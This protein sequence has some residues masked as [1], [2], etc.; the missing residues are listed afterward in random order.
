MTSVFLISFIVLTVNAYNYNTTEV[1]AVGGTHTE[2]VVGQPRFINPIYAN[3]DADRDLVQLTFSGLLKYDRD[4]NI[5]ED[6]AESFQIDSGGTTYT[7]HLKE[8]LKWS[9]GKPLTADDVIFTIQTIQDPNFKSPL[10]ASWVG[11]DIEKIDDLTV[12]F[13]LK[14]PYI[15][16]LENAT[17]PIL[18]KH[19]W[20]DTGAE[21]FAFASYNLNPVGSGMFKVKS[22]KERINSI[23]R[24]VLEQNKYYHDQKP[25]IKEIKFIYYDSEEELIKD[26]KKNKLDGISLSS[27]IDLGPDWENN[28]ISLPRYFAVFFNILES[29]ILSSHNVR[30]ALN[31]ATNKEEIV[32]SV[33]GI[34][35]HNLAS[36]KTVE[37]PI[38]PKIYNFS[39][40]EQVYNFDQQKA[41]EL[42]E[43]EGFMI[44]GDSQVREKAQQKESAFSF[45][46]RL[47]VSSQNQQVTELQKCLAK[48][49][50]V[51]PDGEVTG[52]F[53]N[54]TKEAVILFQEKY[55]E[56]ILAPY[57]YSEGTGSVGPSTRDKLN[58]ICFEK[59]DESTKL[60]FDLA[61]VS[62]PQMKTVALILKDQWSQVGAE[63]NII[64]YSLFQ[65]ERDII[66]PRNYDALLFGEVL[67][68]FPDPFPFWH[69]TQ[70]QDP[71][72]NLALY[73]NAGIDKYLEDNRKEQDPEQRM[74]HLNNFQNILIKDAPVVFLYSPDFVYAVS[75]T[76]GI[77][78][79]KITDPS[80]RFV[81]IEDW[82]AKTRRIW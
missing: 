29:D 38:L 76:K 30:L 73:E 41:R 21:E 82:Y 57:G 33:L 28:L 44:L 66:K 70:T 71:G 43:E 3:T 37:S 51:Y 13:I 20:E 42:L 47:D 6:L 59:S 55:S 15:A 19:I 24:I 16:F 39:S 12:R 4:L 54:K 14:K 56:E 1:P 53:G 25:N 62:Q 23:A 9:D 74:E 35:N 77:N 5:K 80:K 75:D 36:Q 22:V 17:V 67:G 48:D 40:P 31:Y 10:Q 50:S 8:D 27:G 69:S 61:I 32:S 45:T 64:E 26:A 63:I 34:D 81:G 2:G 78:V 65:L 72:L 49:R 58:E 68:A 46:S 79:S 52:Y 60:S 7:F 11:V 18:P